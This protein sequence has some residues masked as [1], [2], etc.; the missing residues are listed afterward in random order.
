MATLNYNNFIKTLKSDLDE[1]VIQHAR[2][3]ENAIIDIINP[4]TGTMDQIQITHKGYVS[5][6]IAKV[7]YVIDVEGVDR[8][9]PDPVE[10]AVVDLADLYEWMLIEDTEEPVK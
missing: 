7:M 10:V 1:N 5:D 3:S 9:S 6:E 8:S 2:I 4:C